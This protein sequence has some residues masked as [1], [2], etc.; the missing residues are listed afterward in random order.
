VSPPIHV[1]IHDVSPVWEREVEQAL[2]LCAA[3]GAR[4]A[5]LVVPDMHHHGPLR[6]TPAYCQ[7]LRALAAEGHE[8]YLHGYYHLAAPLRSG[9]APTEA[10][11]YRIAQRVVSAGEAEFAELDRAE[12]EALLTRG[13]ADLRALELPLHGFVPPAWAR[14]AWLLPALRARSIPFTEDHLFVYQPVTGA[15]VFCPAINYASRTR[16]RRVS[17][18]A[19]ARLARIYPYAGFPVRIAIHPADLRHPLLVRETRSLLAWA[20]G[21]TTHRASD[22]FVPSRD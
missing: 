10:L 3:V 21:R 7:R 6:D 4:P 22:L 17:S 15:R 1:S 12:G 13:I 8:I 20:A 11:R 5:L 14:R 9:S 18:V 19:Y 16:A 2:A